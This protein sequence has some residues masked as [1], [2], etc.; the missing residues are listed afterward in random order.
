MNIRLWGTLM[1]AFAG[2]LPALSQSAV[3]RSVHGRQHRGMLDPLVMSQLPPICDP[4]GPY[5]AECADAVTAIALDASNSYDLNHDHLTFAWSTAQ[6]GA[7]FDDASSAAPVLRVPSQGACELAFDVSVAVSDGVNPPVVCPTTVTIRDTQPP[8]LRCPPDVQVYC[9]SPVDPDHTGWPTMTDHCDKNLVPTWTDEIAGDCPATITRTW[10]LSDACDNAAPAATQMITVVPTPEQHVLSG[11][12]LPGSG[13]QAADVW[14]DCSDPNVSVQDPSQQSTASASI[15]NEGSVVVYPK[16][17]LRWDAAGN[18]IRDTFLTLTN[19][20]SS[21]KVV[22]VFFVVEGF[23]GKVNTGFSLQAHKPLNWSAATG[24]PAGMPPFGSVGTPTPEGND[25]VLRGYALVWA[26][27]GSREIKWNHLYGSA[28]IADYGNGAA[29]EYNAYTFR[30]VNSD[31]TVPEGSPTGTCGRLR[32][33]GYEFARGFDMLLLDFV[34]SG[35]DAFTQ[36]GTHVTHDTELTLLILS[37]DFRLQAPGPR[38]TGLYCCV[39]NEDLV[40]R[41]TSIHCFT[42]SATW[43]LGQLDGVFNRSSLQ[44]DCGYARIDAL[45]VQ[46]CNIPGQTATAESLLGVATKLLTFSSE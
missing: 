32:F 2:T 21:A 35:A 19:D 28:T 41:S 30:A 37:N 1:L 36:V 14:F 39:W 29:W 5:R 15:G 13:L 22:S 20:G 31:T 45:G 42:Q 18:L 12:S 38:R 40:S 25:Y 43:R 34:A 17:E 24:Q 6:P 33:D 27:E 10:R 7:T 3:D 9:G 11:R 8:V 23:A 16:I 4:G 44:T 26:T 46:Q